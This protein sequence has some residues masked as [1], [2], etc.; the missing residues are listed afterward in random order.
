MID[1]AKFNVFLNV[2][3]V[4]LSNTMPLNKDDKDCVLQYNKRGIK[5]KNSF[6]NFVTFYIKCM[7]LTI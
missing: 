6:P 4:T 3:D 2:A 5:C 7:E 1:Y